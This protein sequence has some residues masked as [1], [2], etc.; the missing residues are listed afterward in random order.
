MNE[1]TEEDA[2]AREMDVILIADAMKRV[3]FPVASFDKRFFRA[4]PIKRPTKLQWAHAW[5]CAWKY[6]RQFYSEEVSGQAKIYNSLNAENGEIM[7][8]RT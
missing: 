6:R 8:K 4:M 3:R 1:D 2:Q 5:R 7:A